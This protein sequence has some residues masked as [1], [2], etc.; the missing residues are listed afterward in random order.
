M[1]E[2]VEHNAD[3]E[4]LFLSEDVHDPRM[5]EGVEHLDAWLVAKALRM[6]CMILGCRKALSTR[7]P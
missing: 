2:G 1:P 3:C 5:P 4:W 7:G 6:K